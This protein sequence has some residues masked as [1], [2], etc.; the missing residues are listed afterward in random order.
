LQ[1]RQRAADQRRGKEAVLPGGDVPE[2]GGKSE[3]DQDAGAPAESAGDRSYAGAY[4][5]REPADGGGQIRQR[6]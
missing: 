2:L 1:E 5:R 6:R 4:G 3:R